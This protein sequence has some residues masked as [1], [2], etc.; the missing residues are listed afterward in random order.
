MNLRAVVIASR[1]MLAMLLIAGLVVIGLGAATLILGD[2]PEV[3]GLLRAVFAQVFAV[4]AFGLGAILAIPGAVGLWA[5]AGATATDAAPAL[6]RPVRIVLAG[7]ALVVVVA[8]VVICITAGSAL[9]ILNFG[10]IAL[11]ALAALGL[12]GAAYL[13]PHVG[14]AAVSGVALGFFVAGTSLVLFNA[15]IETPGPA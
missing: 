4:V 14:R 1:T 5:M 7:I 6:P 11:V 13:S 8:T 10:L 12:A 2:P 3:E 9:P 15:F